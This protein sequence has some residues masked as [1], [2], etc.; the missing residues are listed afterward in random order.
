M[1]Y[2]MSDIH[3]ES[4]RFYKMLDLIQFQPEDTLYILG[5]VIDRFPGGVDILLHI[6]DMPNAVMILGNHE[7]MCLDTLGSHPQYGARRLWQSNGGRTTY[8]DLLYHRSKTERDRVLAFL[9]SLP[10]RLEIDVGETSYYLVHASPG[11]DRETRIWERPE[12]YPGMLPLLPDKTVILGHTPTIYFT[13]NME[14]PLHIVFGNRVIAMDCGCG[15]ETD[16]RRLACL[17][18]DDMQGFYV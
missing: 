18:L 11:D 8:Q 1:I 14:E 13:K 3:G 6:M 16:L 15:N 10:D 4:D 2:C 9:E 7:Q 5:D 12:I 17:R